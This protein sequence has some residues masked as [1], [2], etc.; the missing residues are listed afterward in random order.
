[1]TF[2]WHQ[3]KHYIIHALTAKRQGHGVHSPFAYQLCEEVFYNK[4]HFYNFK[5][6]DQIRN[7]LLLNETQLEIKDFGAG[8][9]VLDSKKRKIK[10]IAQFGISS[11]KQ[12]EIFYRLLNFLGSQTILELGTSLG[13]NTLYLAATN[14][15]N[16]VYSIEG[17]SALYDFAKQLAQKNQIN[18]IQFVHAKFDDSLPKL[19]ANMN[20]LDALYIDGNHSYE[21]TLRYF[22]AGLSKKSN[23]SVFIFDDIYWSAE[24]TKAWNV[25]KQHP[26]VKMSIDTFYFGLLFFKEEI[27]EKVE[28][29][30][31]L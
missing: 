6:F 2:N 13:L 23:D 3:I 18:N 15:K 20:S 9:K 24:M 25:L 14:K 30:L 27:K 4:N 16:K 8:S 29:K 17:S 19:L 1:M 21:A 31:F 22:E 5:L 10:D 26:E 12:S 11:K 7:S 28:L